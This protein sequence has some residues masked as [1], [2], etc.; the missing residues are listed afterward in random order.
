MATPRGLWWPFP[1]GPRR[2]GWHL[3]DKAVWQEGWLRVTEAE[4]VDGLLLVDLPVISVR[5]EATRDL[6]PTIR[7]RVENSVVRSEMAAVPGGAARFV[8]RR[9]PGVDGVTWWARL[10]GGTPDTDAAR[11]AVIDGIERL[12]AAW[13]APDL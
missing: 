8:G 9:V 6:P 7:K 1:E 10:E 12:R 2:I 3:I 13:D 11:A 5:L 4:V